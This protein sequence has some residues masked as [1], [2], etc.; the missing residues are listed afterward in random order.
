VTGPSHTLYLVDDHE[1]VREGLSAVLQAA[2]HAVLGESADPTQALADLIRL[3][4]QV[5]VLDLHLGERSGFE[6]LEQVQRRGLPVRT[7]V[8]TMSVQ[9]RS[10]AEALRL[11]AQ[12]YVLKGLP[13]SE[14]LKAIDLAARGQRYL[15]APVAD[16]AWQA[17]VQSDPL[18]RMAGLSP[19]ERQILTLVVSGHSSAA[20][21][22]RLHLSPKTV[23]TYRSRLM[24]K[25]GV[26]DV[27][28]LVR[29]AIR[30]GLIDV[31][32]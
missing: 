16:L 13:S 9:P 32:S 24:S 11:G 30:S 1:I 17:V 5:L 19:R 28:A 2:G 23:D 18:D 29:L 6:L 10:V 7:V 12:A 20:I 21:G 22:E 25:L 15:C 27:P 4:P 14:L 31:E 26:G 3:Q 8:L